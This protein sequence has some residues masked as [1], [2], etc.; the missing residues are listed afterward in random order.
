LLQLRNRTVQSLT[1]SGMGLGLANGS[2][3]D[4]SLAEHQVSLQPDD[5]LMFYTDGISEAMNRA[6]EEFGEERLAAVLL[7]RG[8]NP[9]AAIR[10]HVIAAVDRFVRS[11]PQHDDITVVTVRVT[12]SPDENG[13]TA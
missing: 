13:G 6:R 3:F 7:R 11:A 4:D 12:T 1:P 2:L 5:V 8:G 9:A 10:Q